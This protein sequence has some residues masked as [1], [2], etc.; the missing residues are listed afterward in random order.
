M[1]TNDSR[2]R[3]YNLAEKSMVAKYKGLTNA[4]SQVRGTMSDDGKYVISGS[5]DRH[6]HI[7]DSGID[8]AQTSLWNPKKYQAGQES[9]AGAQA[10]LRSAGRVV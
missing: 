10:A 2:I 7:W 6:I 3:M 5:E 1:T 8:E 4:T 9:F